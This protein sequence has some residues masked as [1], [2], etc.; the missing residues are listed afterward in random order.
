MANYNIVDPWRISLRTFEHNGSSIDVLDEV[1]VDVPTNHAGRAE[2]LPGLALTEDRIGGAFILVPESTSG[3]DP[4]E[5]LFDDKVATLSP[6]GRWLARYNAGPISLYRVEDDLSIT[7]YQALFPPPGSSNWGTE[8]DFLSDTHLLVADERGNNGIQ[9]LY[10]L[11]LPPS[12]ALT[13]AEVDEGAELPLDLSLV[14]VLDI[15]TPDE[16]LTLELVAVPTYGDLLHDGAP[17]QL[18]DTIPFTDVADGLLSYAH[19]GD[20]STSDTFE[21]EAC[22]ADLQCSA[23]AIMDLTI[24]PVNDPPTPV[25]DLLEV[26]EGASA[27]LDPLLND[28]DPDSFLDPSATIVGGGSYGTATAGP[29]GVHYE[30]DGSETTADALTYTVCDVDGACAVGSIE[31]VVI[32]VNDPPTL[33]DGADTV[34][35]GGSVAIDVLASAADP[36]STL[37]ATGLSLASAPSV[38]AV[39]IDASGVATYVHDGSETTAD[40]FELQLC[41]PEG[42]CVTARFDVMVDPVNDAPLPVDDTATVDEGGTVVVELTANDDDDSALASA[43]LAGGPAHGTVTITGFAATY[44]HDGSE[45]VSDTFGYELCDAEGACANAEVVLTVAPVDDPPIPSDDAAELDQGGTVLVDVLANDTDPDSATLTVLVVTQ[46][47]ATEATVAGGRV[48][49]VHNGSD[50]LADTV[51]LEVCDASSCVESRLAVSVR[52][53][54]ASG[55]DGVAS[56]GEGGDNR[57]CGCAI[58]GVGGGV[59]M[60]AVLGLVGRRR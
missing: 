55:P 50:T 60:L 16:D 21:L 56:A 58:G 35:E 20:E 49:L 54:T 6:G 11:Q 31:V 53:V 12:L 9:Y 41:D 44:V 17:L 34:D 10:K 5:H 59:W 52:K 39:T 26:L 33:V 57:G 13:P 22:D 38:G 36:D 14:D 47:A 7:A 30:H 27:S 40:T 4:V 8:V 24:H 25:P 29:Y 45:T 51:G 19:Q 48:N 37:D 2:V 23:V 28:V 15:D 1:V 18:Y 43:A 3:R 42:A 46:G 32:P